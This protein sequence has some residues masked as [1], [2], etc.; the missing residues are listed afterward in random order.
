MMKE[1]AVHENPKIISSHR[2]RP[3]RKCGYE[4]GGHD[5]HCL[6]EDFRAIPFLLIDPVAF[7]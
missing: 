4:N 7:I 3:D 6:H 1:S 5:E 2:D